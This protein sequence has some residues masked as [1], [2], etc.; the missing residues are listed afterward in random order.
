MEISS[1]T[2][3]SFSSYANLEVKIKIST[4]FFQGKSV[5]HLFLP[6]SSEPQRS[7]DSVLKSKQKSFSNV[8]VKSVTAKSTTPSAKRKTTDSTGVLTARK[9]ASFNQNRN[10]ASGNTD[11]TSALSTVPFKPFDIQCP[12]G[13][14]IKS[15]TVKSVEE[16]TRRD[17][18]FDL[19][20]DL[21]PD[22]VDPVRIL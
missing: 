18:V 22:Y 8:T 17:A 1:Q 10:R 21:L 12:L 9:I 15:M 16:T 6:G 19:K 7:A 4:F 20:C 13:S 5:A 2:V 14:A 11:N 3:H